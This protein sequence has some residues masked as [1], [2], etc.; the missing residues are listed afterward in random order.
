MA[1]LVWLERSVEGGIQ[2]EQVN[3]VVSCRW[4]L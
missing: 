3:L 2:E 4:C 1:H